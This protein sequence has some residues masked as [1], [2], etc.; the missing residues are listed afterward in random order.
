MSEFFQRQSRRN[1]EFCSHKNCTLTHPSQRCL[2]KAI[3]IY[4]QNLGLWPNNVSLR[5]IVLLGHVQFLAYCQRERMAYPGARVSEL[6]HCALRDY[7]LSFQQLR[8]FALSLAHVAP[9]FPEMELFSAFQHTLLDITLSGC[10]TKTNALVT[11]INYFPN[12]MHL[13][14]HDLDH[15]KE[16][17]PT[18]PLARPHLEKLYIAQWTTH[19]L[20]RLEELLKQ[21]LDFD[22]LVLASTVPT[23]N[24]TEF[25]KL[26][27]GIFG[28]SLRNLRLFEAPK[29]THSLPFIIARVGP[30]SHLSRRPG[31]LDTLTL[32]RARWAR[33]LGD[34]SE[35]RGVEHHLVGHI[36][37]DRKD[38][39]QSHG[40]VPAL[41]RSHL[42]D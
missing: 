20:E 26:V 41:S 12:L 39:T 2:F 21:G 42:L 30:Q 29:G 7:L 18:V 36:H 9:S 16:G 15:D 37:Q 22:G 17:E 11:V 14:L 28:A 27:V 4:P 24:W 19:S 34:T 35:R 1:F 23:H 31:A 8:Y 3:W 33:G 38:H 6:V 13:H 10:S 32:S 25:A 5:S 40:R